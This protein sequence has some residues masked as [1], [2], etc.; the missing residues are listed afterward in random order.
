MTS[1][2]E[3][4]KKFS[5]VL[6]LNHTCDNTCDNTCGI[7][8]QNYDDTSDNYY[9]LGCG[10]KFHYI[11]IDN[12]FRDALEK[13]NYNNKYKTSFMSNIIPRECPYCRA[14]S[15]LIDVKMNVK[16]K[17]G[18]HTFKKNVTRSIIKKK[19]IGICKN[20]NKCKKSGSDKYNGYCFIHKDQFNENND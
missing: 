11:C 20:G 2:I 16:P 3:L 18:I 10:H 6:D 7:C 17:K 12:Y 4:E 5:T 9:E 19:C 8:K 13:Y 15:S 14:K 1:L